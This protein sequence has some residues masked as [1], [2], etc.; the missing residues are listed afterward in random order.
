MPRGSGVILGPILQREINQVAQAALK[1]LQAENL[2]VC[3]FGSTACLFYGMQYR[4]PHDVDLVVMN[5][6]GL[7]YD[8][9]EDI[10]HLLVRSNHRF[11]LVNSQRDRTATWKVLYYRLGGRD[12]KRRYKV[13]ILVPGR[14]SIPRITRND[15][16]HPRV[17]VMPLLTLI[18]LKLRGWMDHRHDYR[19]WMTAK[20]PQD[21]NDIEEMVLLAQAVYGWTVW[22]TQG[23]RL[24]DAAWWTPEF[25]GDVLHWVEEFVRAGYSGVEADVVLVGLL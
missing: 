15:F 17:P 23:E 19:P 22:N 4:V 25:T 16:P 24:G 14:L 8:D 10:K 21:E 11:F 18:V 1:V 7:G 13:D 9:S 5:G 6:D 20:V 12:S 3:L 2:D